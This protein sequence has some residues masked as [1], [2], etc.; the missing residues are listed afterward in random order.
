MYRI[1][2]DYLDTW[3]QR[4]RRK[5]LVIR[6]ARQVG[7]SHLVRMFAE[8]HFTHL[9]EL[10]FEYEPEDASLFADRPP[11]ETLRL[12][13]AKYD[14][15]VTPGETL[16]FL[17]EIQQAP[18]ILARLRYFYEK[19]PGLHVVAAGSLLDFALREHEFSMPVG[20]I[21]YLH[22]G[23]MTF[24]EFLLASNRPGLVE[25]LANYGLGDEIPPAMHSELMRL[26]KQYCVVGGMPEAVLAHTEDKE[27]GACDQAKQRILA[28]YRDDF[29]KYAPRADPDLIRTVFMAV[30]KMVGRKFVYS[31]A[32]PDARHPA[33]KRAFEQLCLARVVAKAPHTSA[34]GLPLGTDASGRNFKV[35]FLDVGLLCRACGLGAF[36][37]EQARDLALVNA[38]AVVEQYVG[39]HLLLTREPYEDPEL[40]CWMRQR[41]SSNAEIDYLLSVGATVVPVEVKAGKTGSLKSLHVFVNERAARFALRFNAAVPSEVEAMTSISGAS[42]LPFRL[43]S[44]PFYLIGQTRRLCENA[45]RT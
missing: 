36:E 9:L 12:L 42:A 40:Y 22:M 5:P 17:D 2:L 35:V 15:P 28:T 45:L 41:K 33:V 39:Q 29:S 23:P 16:L 3:R 44:L 31:Q 14:V 32:A 1:A 10:N 27:L 24:E 19:L 20:R 18:E 8:R 6:G 38:G 34:V 11:A 26:V 30:P 13:Q 37:L 25:F 4:R 43:L 7:K 21:E